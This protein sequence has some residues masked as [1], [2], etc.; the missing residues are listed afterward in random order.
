MSSDKVLSTPG[1]SL[2]HQP[3]RRASDTIVQADLL[4]LRECRGG[5]AIGKRSV[6]R[7]EIIPGSAVMAFREYGPP[8]PP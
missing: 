7:P 5:P 2:A 1:A 4:R 3:G 6:Q 8:M